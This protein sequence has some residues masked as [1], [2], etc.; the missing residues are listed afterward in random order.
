MALPPLVTV[1]DLAA[2]VGQSIPVDDPRAVAVLAAASALVRSEAGQA[3]ENPDTVADDVK[4][5]VT[6][7]AGRVW[8][9]PSGAI[10]RGAGPYSERVSERAAE[11]LF[12]TDT[13]KEVLTRYRATRRGLWTMG[14]TVNGN[15]SPRGYVPTGPPPS[16]QPFPWYSEEG[17]W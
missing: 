5:I 9:N 15:H 7:A 6:Q 3:W 4:L 2:W 16:G 10:Q 11:G 1:T 17:L 14:V 12:L 13:E 8:N